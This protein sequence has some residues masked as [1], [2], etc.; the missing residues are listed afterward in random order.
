VDTESYQIRRPVTTTGSLHRSGRR[1]EFSVAD[2]RLIL[3]HIKKHRDDGSH[4]TKIYET[5]AAEVFSFTM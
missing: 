2:D 1:N 3:A 5:L 4:G